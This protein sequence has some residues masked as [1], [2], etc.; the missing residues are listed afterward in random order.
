WEGADMAAGKLTAAKVKTMNTPGLHSDGDGLYLQIRG[1]GVCSWIYRFSRFNRVRQMGLG[2]YPLVSLADAR[3]LR[4][5]AKRQL[6]GEGID[7]IK[8]RKDKLEEEKRKTPSLTFQQTAEVYLEI[9]RAELTQKHA[10]QWRA[11]LAAD[12]FPIMGNIPVRD[13]G[14]ED[15]LKALK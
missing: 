12:V 8:A 15:V 2:P 10:D 1:P 6:R 7:P 11:S 13:I 14:T 5:K 9:K 4:H 3:K